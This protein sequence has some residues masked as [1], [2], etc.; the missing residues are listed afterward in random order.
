MSTWEHSRFRI[1]NP[2][3]HP[4]KHDFSDFAYNN[5]KLPVGLTN[6]QEV[7]D[8]IVD[9]MYPNALPSVN[10]KADMPVSANAGDYIFVKDDGDGHGAGYVWTVIDG[11]SKWVKRLDVDW[12]LE[13]VLAETVNRTT[14]L[15]PAKYGMTDQDENGAPVTGV[16]AGQSIWGGDQD[17]QNLTLHATTGAGGFV[18]VADPVRPIQNGLDLGTAAQPFRKLNA[19]LADIDTLSLAAGSITDDSGLIDFGATAL[20]TTGKVTAADVEASAHVKAGALTLQSGSI[21]DGSGGIS[22]GGCTLTTTN[23]VT[24]ASGSKFG[25]VTLSNG[26]ITDSSGA[27]SFG[28]DNLTT[29]GALTASNSVTTSLVDAGNLRIS[30]NSL[31]AQN[32]NGSIS[33]TPNG[34]GT[35]A[36]ASDTAVSGNFTASG[37][38]TVTGFVQGGSLKLSGST[39]SNTVLNGDIALSTTGIGKVTTN[40][41]VVPTVD[42]SVDLGASGKAIRHLHLGSGIYYGPSFMQAGTLFSLSKVYWRDAAQTQL[43]QPGDS[44]FFDGTQWLASHP[45]SE[46][47]HSELTGLTSGD[48]GHTQFAMLAGRAGGQSIIGG[49]G[50]NETLTLESTSNASKGAIYAKDHLRPFT[51]ASYSGGWTGVDLG[52]ASYKFRDVYATG[53]FKGLRFENAT[54]SALPSASATTVGRAVYTTDNKKIYLDTGGTWMVAGVSKFV[55]DS[56]WTG[57]TTQTFDVSS[58]I[59]DAR[60]AVWSVTDN[61]NNFERI[62]PKIEAISA[63]Q[64]RITA[65]TGLTG[66]FRII[67][68]E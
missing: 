39:I 64:V 31:T 25:N 30:G 20:E 27:I 8:Y 15:Y 44:L 36:I 29:S 3:Q 7:L 45:D 18:Q 50:A 51:N 43:A 34:T 24:G 22:F 52:G 12:N 62:Y 32:V 38:A 48:G 49:T 67:G 28:T 6:L 9:V 57:Q 47:T 13:H 1:F 66:T 58:A 33:L 10:T 35:V 40:T 61:A 41:S 14:W 16:L 46:V 37:N 2:T 55:S 65:N 60:L 54:S 56:V 63:T 11:S 4:Y 59:G 19:V 42:N 26:S 68:I 17:N 23:T 5:E 21:T 53:E